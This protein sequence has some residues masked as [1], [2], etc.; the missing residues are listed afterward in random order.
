MDSIEQ[1]IKVLP[2]GGKKEEW[3]IR[4]VQWMARA[5][6]KKWKAVMTGKVTPPKHDDT[7]DETTNDG[8]KQAAE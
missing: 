5:S 1:I 8:K 4:S 7:L 6:R 2:F 3:R